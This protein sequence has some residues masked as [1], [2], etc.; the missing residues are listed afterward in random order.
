MMPRGMPSKWVKVLP[1]YYTSRR[2]PTRAAE[3]QRVLIEDEPGEIIGYLV[4][5]EPYH[6]AD[7]V[8]VRAAP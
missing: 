4:D 6:P 7:V 1:W 8:I 3:F 2:Q 5:G